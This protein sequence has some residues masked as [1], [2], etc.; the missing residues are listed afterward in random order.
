VPRRSPH[1]L[2]FPSRLLKLNPRHPL[3]HP[4][5]DPKQKVRIVGITYMR[6]RG[7]AIDYEWAITSTGGDEATKSG[8]EGKI[9]HGRTLGLHRNLRFY[10]PTVTVFSVSFK[11]FANL[12]IY[13]CRWLSFV[14][15]L[16]AETAASQPRNNLRTMA[17]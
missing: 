17:S 11:S 4:H 14:K 9:F 8:S 10:S 6:C 13:A 12:D 1:D 5:T 3:P 7:T 16:Q 15:S 2:L